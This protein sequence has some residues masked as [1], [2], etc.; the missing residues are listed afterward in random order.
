MEV[1]NALLVA[2]MF[3]VLLT[4][5]IGNIIAALAAIIDKRT[6]MKADPVHTSWVLLLL[7][8]HFN[9]FWHVLDILSIEHWAF[10]EFLYIV[11][12]AA[13]MFFATHVLL[14]DATSTAT[15]VRSHYFDVRRQ[16]FVLLGLLMIWSIGVD[17][18]L[19]GDGLTPSGVGNL[20]GLVFF[21]AMALLSQPGI[22]KVGAGVGWVFFV[23]MLTARGLGII[24]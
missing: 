4:M 8:M 23:A 6:P 21:S 2:M 3:I 5:G 15:D 19:A 20:I 16:F 14:P 1:T 24:D 22:H 10:L 13:I 9:L 12:G 17:V 18:I 11:A 7:L